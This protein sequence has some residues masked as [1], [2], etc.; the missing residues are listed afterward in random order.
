MFPFFGCKTSSALAHTCGTYNGI[1]E[2][3]TQAELCVCLSVNQVE[4]EPTPLQALPP[5]GRSHLHSA[6]SVMLEGGLMCVVCASRGH[7][8]L[9]NR[10]TPV[11]RNLDDLIHFNVPG[12]HR[13]SSTSVVSFVHIESVSQLFGLIGDCHG[14]R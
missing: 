3:D 6:D 4:T 14:E 11:R 7:R 9:A 13:G 1:G 12:L 2:M 5:G 10:S 8:L